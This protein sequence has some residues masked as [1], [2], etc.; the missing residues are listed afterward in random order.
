[1]GY[2]DREI[3]ECAMTD[4][5][6]DVIVDQNGLVVANP[7]WGDV[8]GLV[9]GTTTRAA[10][11]AAHPFDLFAAVETLRAAGVL[12]RRFTFGGEQ[13]HGDTIA[14]IDR[15][16]AFGHHPPGFRWN[17]AAQVG[18]YPATDALATNIP[19][20]L[21]VI[22][23][24]DCLPVYL[25]DRAAHVVGLAH[26][27]WKGTLAGLAAKTAREVVALG[28]KAENIEAWIGPGI[29]A[30]NYE[31]G[32]ELIA[33]FNERFPSGIVSSNGTHLNLA[34]VVRRQLT[35]AGLADERI[36]DCG[37]CTLGDPGR[38]YSY[39]GEGAGTGRMLSFIGLA[40]EAGPSDGAA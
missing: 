2:G 28:A 13:V 26:C 7:A 35:D 11:P 14:A 16:I 31:V 38:Y 1:M 19:G 36:A 4:D 24:A 17:E 15:P 3:G 34:A 40:P 22:R 25:L 21:L 8:A 39:R 9:H 18:E 23:T 6:R 29:C 32:A 37:E 33:Q 12:P 10:L 27:G 20:L 30:A 5:A